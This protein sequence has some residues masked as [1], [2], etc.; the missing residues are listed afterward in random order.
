MRSPFYRDRSV[1]MFTGRDARERSSHT[2]FYSAKKM[3]ESRAVVGVFRAICRSIKAGERVSDVDRQQLDAVVSKIS[4]DTASLLYVDLCR[5]QLAYE[6]KSPPV[7]SLL[8]NLLDWNDRQLVERF[9]KTIIDNGQ[10]VELVADAV[11]LPD[12]KHRMERRSTERLTLEATAR[13]HREESEWNARWSSF[14]FDSR[15]ENAEAYKKVHAKL[16]GMTEDRPLREWELVILTDEESLKKR[17][18][19]FWY[20]VQVARCSDEEKQAVCHKL[21]LCSLTSAAAAVRRIRVQLHGDL[22]ISRFRNDTLHWEDAPDAEPGTT[23][24]GDLRAPLSSLTPPA[25]SSAGDA[26]PP[27]GVALQNITNFT[28]STDETTHN[29]PPPIRESAHPPEFESQIGVRTR[30]RTF[31]QRIFCCP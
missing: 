15:A 21:S 1:R 29:N 10:V 2:L 3:R 27:S 12:V 14:M 23:P 8:K 16:L 19:T 30:R 6:Q 22:F 13:T 18:D 5:I 9:Q 17:P 20:A 24:R 7:L 11:E 31:C 26:S 25:A 4:S 28:R